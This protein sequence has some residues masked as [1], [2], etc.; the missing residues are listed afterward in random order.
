LWE[1]LQPRSNNRGRTEV[2]Q[3]VDGWDFPLL[4]PSVRPRFHGLTEWKNLLLVRA[5]PG[6][7]LQAAK[8]LPACFSIR[9]SELAGLFLTVFYFNVSKADYF[10]VHAMSRELKT[11]WEQASILSK[12][13]NGPIGAIPPRVMRPRRAS[14]SS[15]SAAEGQSE[16]AEKQAE[17]PCRGN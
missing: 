16:E 17:Q 10:G 14:R 9:R 4:K 5:V 15:N 8:N 2:I 1:R 11:P 7:G 12:M 3:D 13:S 6:N